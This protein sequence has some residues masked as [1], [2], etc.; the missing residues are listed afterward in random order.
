[1][2][3]GHTRIL[4]LA[5]EPEPTRCSMTTAVPVMQAL[6]A[7]QPAKRTSVYAAVA[8]LESDVVS[9]ASTPPTAAR[10]GRQPTITSVIS[11]ERVKAMM[12]PTTKVAKCCRKVPTFWIE[13]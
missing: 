9:L 10:K 6:K 3:C 4:R 8:L 1:M 2:R 13:G 11:Q 5:A 12:K 7:A